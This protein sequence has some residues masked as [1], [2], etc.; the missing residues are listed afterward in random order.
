MNQQMQHCAN[1]IDE[2]DGILAEF[3]IATGVSSVPVVSATRDTG[4]VDQDYLVVKNK[5]LTAMKSTFVDKTVCALHLSSLMT[6]CYQ[7]G[8]EFV[9]QHVTPGKRVF[10]FIRTPGFDLTVEH[11]T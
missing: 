11:K 2:L 10:F 6:F 1:L 3:H 5:L 7:C 4:I 9:T 8:Y